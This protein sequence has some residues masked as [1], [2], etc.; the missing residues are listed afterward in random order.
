MATTRSKALKRSLNQNAND[1]KQEITD[2]SDFNSKQTK[3]SKKIKTE[4]VDVENA[5]LNVNKKASTKNGKEIKFE[6]QNSE[7][8]ESSAKGSRKSSRNVIKEKKYKDEESGEEDKE[9]EI[10]NSLVMKSKANFEKKIEDT[11]KTVKF[12]GKIPVDEE[13]T[14]SKCHSGY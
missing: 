7:N 12:T 6:D 4:T 13:F 14:T 10:K 1:S 2:S 8:E 9:N 3:S 11:V 5:D